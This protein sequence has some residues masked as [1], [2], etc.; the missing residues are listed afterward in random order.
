MAGSGLYHAENITDNETTHDSAEAVYVGVTQSI[1]LYI[2]GAWY[3]FKGATA[4]SLL[5]IAATGA[6]KT[7]AG[8]APD[9]G[10]IVFLR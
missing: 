10:D 9:A 4:D 7:A 6:R 8:A 3:T 5:P 1:D 2:C